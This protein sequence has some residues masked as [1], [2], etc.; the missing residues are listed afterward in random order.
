V[1][2]PE[3]VRALA[4]Q[5][6]EFLIVPTALNVSWP[7]VADKLIPTRAFENGIYVAYANHAGSENGLDYYGH[8]CIATPKGEF[9]AQA[10]LDQ[11]IIAA[12]ISVQCVKAAQKRLPYLA[13]VKKI[14]GIS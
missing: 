1:E 13:D 10:G 5:G 11:E 7:V 6:V 8:S 2:F 12:G 4:K 9:A 14:N 3:T